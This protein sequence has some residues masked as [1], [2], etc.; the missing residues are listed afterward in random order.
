MPAVTAS[1]LRGSSRCSRV[2]GSSRGS[3]ATAPAISA[4]PIG[5]FTQKI[6][7]QP[8]P[9]VIRPPAITPTD[10]AAPPVAP[11][12]PSAISRSFFSVNVAATTASADGAIIAAPTP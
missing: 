6:Q 5:M 3:T 4:T 11:K 8:G 2:W 12:M 9:S 7:D 1:A 10:A